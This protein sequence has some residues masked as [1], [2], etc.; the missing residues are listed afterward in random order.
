M[1]AFVER[2]IRLDA[3]RQRIRLV[4]GAGN[5][6]QDHGQQFIGQGLADGFDVEAEPSADDILRNCGDCTVR[7]AAG[8]FEDTRQGAVQRLIEEY[9]KWSDRPRPRVSSRD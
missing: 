8:R 9:A 5:Q 4:T 7:S 3:A 1:V 2:D 6:L